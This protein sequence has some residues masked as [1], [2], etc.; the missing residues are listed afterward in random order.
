MVM[1]IVGLRRVNKLTIKLL[2]H[3]ASTVTA[4]MQT[5]GICGYVAMG[6]LITTLLIYMP[7]LYVVRSSDF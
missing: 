4:E 1:T 7:F 2:V 5:G 3:Q 6:G